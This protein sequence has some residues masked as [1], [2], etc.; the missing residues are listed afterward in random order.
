[1]RNKLLLYAAGAGVL[2]Y[3]LSKQQAAQTAPPPP[4]A[5]GC[6]ACE[7]AAEAGVVRTVLSLQPGNPY[8]VSAQYD[9]NA[10]G[11]T[12]PDPNAK[13]NGSLGLPAFGQPIYY[14]PYTR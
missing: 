8:G 5:G 4:I 6:A 14:A 13:P 10:L 3:L 2:Y 9:I 12:F 1:M 11:Y 7:K